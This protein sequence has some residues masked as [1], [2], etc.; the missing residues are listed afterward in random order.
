M[1]PSSTR[2]S[3]FRPKATR[4]ACFEHDADGPPFQQELTRDSLG[5]IVQVAETWLG[6]PQ[7]MSNARLQVCS[8]IAVSLT[9]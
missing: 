4:F 1:S 5:R 9:K 2:R 6:P 3:T 8:A 7:R